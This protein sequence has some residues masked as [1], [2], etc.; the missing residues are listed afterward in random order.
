[1]KVIESIPILDKSVSKDI[2]NGFVINPKSSIEL[3]EKINIL[4]SDKS[5]L[6]KYGKNGLEYVKE[7]FSFDKFKTTF[8]KILINE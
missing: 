1:M 6:K 4:H 3:I 7:E 5:T 8:K 2:P